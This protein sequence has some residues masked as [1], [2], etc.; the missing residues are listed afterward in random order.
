MDFTA[1]G[2]RMAVRAAFARKAELRTVVNASGSWIVVKE[3]PIKVLLPM[4]VS[5]EG[6]VTEASDAQPLNTRSSN[7]VMP[8]GMETRSKPEQFSNAPIPSLVSLEDRVA[9]VIGLFSAN[10]NLPTAVVAVGIVIRVKAQ[11]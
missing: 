11:S 6:S 3:Q 9:L 4:L 5:P 1:S 7:F 10:A 8:E 2:K